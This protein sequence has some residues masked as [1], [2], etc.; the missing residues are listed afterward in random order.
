MGATPG[1][2]SAPAAPC[3]RTCQSHAGGAAAGKIPRGKMRALVRAQWCC[4][5][6][7]MGR[8]CPRTHVFVRVW[9]EQQAWPCVKPEASARC[10][11]ME[12]L[13]PP[14]HLRPMAWNARRHAVSSA[15]ACA[16][17]IQVRASHAR[18]AAIPSPPH[19]LV[20]L[21]QRHA[22]PLLCELCCCHKATNAAAHHN[23]VRLASAAGSAAG[24]A[25][26]AA[27][28]GCTGA[29]VAAA[30]GAAA[31]AAAG[32]WR[33]SVRGPRAARAVRA[34]LHA[35]A[36]RLRVLVELDHAWACAALPAAG[37]VETGNVHR[38]GRVMDDQAQASE[39]H[40]KHTAWC[41]RVPWQQH[42]AWVWPGQRWGWP[43]TATGF[44]CAPCAAS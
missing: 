6:G 13:A 4:L 18:T 1:A 17:C 12:R 11:H 16:A 7:C 33:R 27:A 31:H 35:A 40:T 41:T 29:A 19:L 24:C 22:Q 39:L 36:R 28:A 37:A 32:G 14:P 3:A 23:R 30:E 34:R 26:A 8:P 10:L 42:W 21:Q 43:G 44:S 20:L 2:C 25:A 15:C 38:T 5:R 9:E